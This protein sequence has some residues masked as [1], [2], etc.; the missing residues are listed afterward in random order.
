MT[1]LYQT[2]IKMPRGSHYGSD[3]W[4]SYSYKLKRKVCLY[5]MLEYANFIV[6]EMNPNVDFFC[7]QPCKIEENKTARISSSVLDFWVHYQDSSAEFQE[8]KYSYELVG[9]GDAAER[10]QR[11]IKFQHDWCVENGYKY[12]VM[13]E[14]EL[15]DG[16]FKIQNLQ[17]LQSHI[18]RLEGLNTFNLRNFFEMIKTRSMS[19]GEI[20]EQRIL[21]ND[22]ELSILAYQHYLGNIEIDVKNR[23]IDNCTEVKVCETKNIIF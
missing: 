6:L 4:I 15:Y 21:P 1:Y 11:Q 18:L 2:P 9:T 22:M 20:K 17:L 7:E 19:I 10:S 13:T 12:K 5:S 16:P 23:P 3:Y 8:V 14:K